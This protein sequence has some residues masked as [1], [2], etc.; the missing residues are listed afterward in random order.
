MTRTVDDNPQGPERSPELDAAIWQ[1]LDEVH[2]LLDGP[3]GNDPWNNDM[4]MQKVVLTLPRAFVHL[5]AFLAVVDEEQED[6]L[7]FWEYAKTTPDDSTAVKH[8]NRMRNLYL[9]ATLDRAMH[10]TLHLL[11]TD[12]LQL[13]GKRGL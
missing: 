10:M 2:D 4:E 11:A 13:C 3:D 12:A 6:P 9:E 7:G 1:L 8:L 5:A